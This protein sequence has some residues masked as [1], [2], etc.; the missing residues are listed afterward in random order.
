[1]IAVVHIL[2]PFVTIFQAKTV[3]IGKLGNAP[4]ETLVKVA[5]GYAADVGILRIHRYVIQIV[6]PAEDAQF[7]DF[8]H[9]GQKAE[10]DIPILG[11]HH[12]VEALKSG[13]I[14]VHKLTVP[15]IVHNRLVVFIDKNHYLPMSLF[16]RII[17]DLLE[18][19]FNIR[20]IA[21]A[22]K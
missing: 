8:R 11:F 14:V 17:N 16:I 18:S 1:M 7:P 19:R 10:T 21:S 4:V 6:E 15:Q 20:C 2:K 12:A 5:L 22:I 9:S 3:R 13:F